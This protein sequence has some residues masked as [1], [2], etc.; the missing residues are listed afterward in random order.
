MKTI[1]NII[2][3]GLLLI[4]LALA[5]INAS[6]QT[7]VSGTVKDDKGQTVV[8]A[9]VMLEGSSTVGAVTDLNGKYLLTIPSGVNEP[10]LKVSCIGYEDISEALGN[11]SSVDF[12]LKDNAE[13]LEEVVVVG[14]GT[15][16]KSDLTGALSSIKIDEEKAARANT[17]DDFLSGHAAGVQV[18]SNSGAPDAAVT[19]RVRG[20]ST[21]SSNIDPLYVVDGVILNGSSESETMLTKGLDNSDGD[22]ASN[23]LMGINPQDI[24][25]IEIL[26]DA[27]ATAI[28]GA[29]GAN[30]VVLITTKSAMKDRPVVTFST[31][32]DIASRYKKA[33]ILSFEEFSNY[34]HEKVMMG[35]G[36]ESM[37]YLKRMYADPDNMEGLKVQPMD[38]QDY[39]FR[40]A[41]SQKYYFSVSGRPK[42]F[43][44][45]FSLGFND[46]Q[47]IVK[48][49]STKQYTGRLNLDK[50]FGKVIRIG[51][52]TSFSYVDSDLTQGTGGGRMTAATSLVRSML[53]S[54]PSMP[55]ADEESLEE[56]DDEDLRTGPTKWLNKM[57]FINYR[58]EY[59]VTPSLFVEWRFIP[60]LSFKSSIGGDYK[61]SERQKFK[62][63]IIS[64]TYGTNAAASTIERF[65][66]NWDNVFNYNKKFG[67][68]HN[69]NAMAGMSMHKAQMTSQTIEGWNI[70]QY[71]SGMEAL[72]TAPDASLTYSESEN[73]TLSFF[74]RG[75]YSYKDRYVL[76]A[77]F[78]ADGSSRFKGARQ[79]SYFPSAAFA[80][81]VSEE[82]W[83][84]SD[85]VSNTKLRLGWGRTGNQSLSNYQTMSTYGNGKIPTLDQGNL[86]EYTTAIFPDN[87]ANPSLRWETTEQYNAGLDFGMWHGR[88]SFTLDAYY[89]NTFDLLQRKEIPPSSG[90]TEM[91]VN[92]GTIVNR[93]VEFTVDAVPLKV[94]DFE[95][96]VAGNISFNR[97]LIKS[98]NASATR[99]GIW[100]TPSECKEVVFFEGHEAGTGSYCK[101]PV[102]IFMEGYPMGLFYGY[103]TAGIVG[104]DEQGI[105]LSNGGAPGKTGEI[106]Y[107]DLH[108]NGY[109]DEDDRTIIGNPNPDFNYGFDLN[110]SYRRFT[111]G[112]G[113]VGQHG[114]DIFNFNNAVE[115]DTYHSSRNISGRAFRE[116]WTPEHTDTKFPALGMI[117]TDDM[118]KFSDLY[119]ED[120][121]YLRLSNITLGYS[122]PLK[123]K[124]LKNISL[125]VSANNVWVWTRYSGWDP[126]VNSFGNNLMKMGVDS[127]SY[128]TGRSV[129]FDIKLIF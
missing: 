81:R 72:N 112:A 67:G 49:T 7:T 30:G 47:G 86:A 45:N 87:L 88:L 32:V 38:W 37:T 55:F 14:Y 89:K 128:P 53:S 120:G 103:K 9:A 118:S 12:V 127:G 108:E 126:D 101:V 100:V 43:S 51:T 39:T 92:E 36:S 40:T 106:N 123:D 60:E 84:K 102:N 18:V 22:E 75:I 66:W 15:V 111:L 80:W 114:F 26:K 50:K 1:Y 73:Q 85:I 98:I 33:D 76:T 31:G 54:R 122:I 91:Y 20:L 105:A 17:I 64:R 27:S 109:L 117:R 93:G 129:S 79:W 56:D 104:V 125:H 61:N 68:S 119:V 25:S 59:R 107:L 34:L 2:L 94:G 44:Y 57:H 99:K 48:G 21:F 113:F 78:R 16:R 4:C 115:Y 70:P 65:T 58:K 82:P 121:S 35:T 83:F 42:S 28:Y 5:G 19:V 52:K 62:S 95:M 124:I 13:T 71:K 41:V 46:R 63:E 110:F 23:G 10:R 69:V 96:S 8:G 3:R 116:A 74:V 24:E 77:T 6:A 97:N 29:L 11:R 90:F